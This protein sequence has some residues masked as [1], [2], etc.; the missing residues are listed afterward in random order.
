MYHRCYNVYFI[1]ECILNFYDK[2]IRI[3]ILKDL[4][5]SPNQVHTL[6]PGIT[7]KSNEY[8]LFPMGSPN[9]AIAIIDFSDG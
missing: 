9:L 7:H 4:G 6:L 8:C 1:R 2:C 3:S 5:V